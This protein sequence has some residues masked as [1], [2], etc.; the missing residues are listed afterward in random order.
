MRPYRDVATLAAAQIAC[1]VLLEPNFFLI[2]LYES[3][4]YI[5]ILVM[6]F[7]HGGSLGVHDWH[8]GFGCMVG[9]CV[10]GRNIGQGR[11]ANI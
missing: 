2:H 1:F 3:I 4:L 5:A 6:L 10:W 9:A 11:V 8:D 7:L